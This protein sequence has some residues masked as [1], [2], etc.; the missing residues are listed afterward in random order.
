MLV[1]FKTG[2]V[3]QRRS[4]RPALWSVSNSNRE[5][6]CSIITVTFCT[7]QNSMCSQGITIE[8]IL[9]KCSRH[10][11]PEKLQFGPWKIKQ[12]IACILHVQ[13]GDALAPHRSFQN[14]DFLDF[15]ILFNIQEKHYYSTP[16]YNCRNRVWTCDLCLLG[17][18]VLASIRSKPVSYTHLT[19][20]TKA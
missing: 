13:C 4:F 10:F 12:A 2:D 5:L 14:R 18:Y 16:K 17:R 15:S 19:L 6:G 1:S 9:C 11:N 3:Q 20:P 8:T 7:I